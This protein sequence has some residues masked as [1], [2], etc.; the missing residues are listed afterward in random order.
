M[1]SESSPAADLCAR[2]RRHPPLRPT[3][4]CAG[5]LLAQAGAAGPPLATA[6]LTRHLPPGTKIGRYRIVELLGEGG[7]AE[8]YSARP[9]PGGADDGHA[10]PLALKI[11]KRGMDSREIL[12]RFQAEQ[13]AVRALSH[14]SIVPLL[15]AGF[16]GDGLPFFAMA[17]VDGLPITE[18]CQVAGLSL[19]QRL[20]L[21]LPLCDA[22]QHAHQRGV[23]HRDLKPS[24][25]LVEDTALGPVPKVIDFGIAKA[26]EPGG[27]GDTHITH[28][29]VVLGTP[30]YMSPEQANGHD[31]ADTRSDI[32]SLGALLYEMLTGRPPFEAAE[33][34]RLRAGQWS[35]YLREHVPPLPS[36][37]LEGI[38]PSSPGRRQLRGNLDLVVR[39]A[40]AP[41]PDRR[42]ASAAA[43]AEDVSA[44]LEDRP[45]SASPPTLRDLT[46]QFIRQHRWP[47]A[48]GVTLLAGIVATAGIGTTLAIQARRAEG[49]AIA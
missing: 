23:L 35:R 48:V 9:E 24:N 10:Y 46:G 39:K 37:R 34:Q 28:H 13:R 47:V 40:M 36:A 15:E 5:C 38:D 30:T 1:P 44:C 7:F 42:Y 20:E 3:H 12:S 2:C 4:Y 32:Y 19:R 16:T 29:G 31:E 21:F 49:R 25:V 45:V 43:F 11:V 22:V 33:L 14:P 18:Y 8:V 41:E 6:G 17:Q 27:S 26:L